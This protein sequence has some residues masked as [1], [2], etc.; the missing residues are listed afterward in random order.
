MEQLF[1]VNLILVWLALLGQFL[2]TFAL[3]RKVNSINE[4]TDESGKST[5]KFRKDFL[6]VGHL[7]PDFVAATVTGSLVTVADYA[8]CKVAFIFLLTWMWCPCRKAIP[9]LETL[10]PLAEKNG[11]SLT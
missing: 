1:I 2:L 7:A 5:I 9:T 8:Q 6:K 3:I 11:T 10:G 4:V